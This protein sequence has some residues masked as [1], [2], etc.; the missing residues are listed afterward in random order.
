MHPIKR[1]LYVILSV[2]VLTAGIW[3][4][5]ANNEEKPGRETIRVGF[6]AT[7][8]LHMID[9]GGEKTGYG[10][11]LLRYMSRYLDVS[12][13]YVGYDKSWAEMLR[14]LDDG[15]IDMVAFA[16][17]TEERKEKYDFSRPIGVFGSALFVRED[18]RAVI[19]RDYST[20]EGLRI[21]LVEGNAQNKDIAALAEAMHFTYQP[22]ICKSI[23]DVG[24]ALQKGEVDA[25]V[26]SSLR[27]GIHEKQ[28]ELFAENPHYIIVKKGN[29]R[30]LSEINYAL[31]QLTQV[32]GDWKARLY[33]RYYGSKASSLLQFSDKEKMLLQSYAANGV[34]LQVL[35]DPARYPYSYVENGEMKGIVPDYF[36]RVAA[37][38]GLPFQFVICRSREEWIAYRNRGDC[39]II[40]DGR[41]DAENVLE[42]KDWVSTKPYMTLRVAQV[43]RRDFDGDIQTVATVNQG[44][45]DPIEDYYSQNVR[46]VSYPTRESAMQA[47]ADGKA[48]AAYVFYYMAQEYVNRDQSGLLS[49]TLM[50]EPS[51]PCRMIVTQHANHA[52]AGILTK[53]IYDMPANLLEQIASKYTSYKMK[54]MTFLMMARLHPTIAILLV[55]LMLLLIALLAMA[56]IRLRRM[57][58]VEE[59]KA[60]EMASL[61]EQAEAANRAKSA[62]LSSISHDI[63]TPMNAIIGFTNIALQKEPELSIRKDL[64]KIDISSQHLLTLLNDVLDISRIESGKVKFQP[65]AVDLT[66]LMEGVLEITRG[67]ITDRVLTLSENVPSLPHPFVMADEVRLREVLVNLFSNA[68]KYTKDGGKIS[69]MCDMKELDETHVEVTYEISD[70]G[71]GM[72]EDFV[73][74]I[75]ERFTQEDAG[76]A[77]T[78]YKGAGLGM[79]IT[80]NYVELMGGTI[81]VRSQK[82]VGSTFTVTL[83]MEI[84]DAPL[85]RPDHDASAPADLT[86][87]HV[88]LAEDN[89]LN[90]EIATVQLESLGVD[91]T[92]AV[93]GKEALQLFETRPKGTFDLI[94][95]DIMMPEMDGYEATR[96]IR[97]LAR[98]D[99]RT[100]PILAMTANAF[101]EDVEKSKAAGMNGHLSKPIEIHVVAAMIAKNLQGNE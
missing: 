27:R 89:D 93:N 48:D 12:Y 28:V 64:E 30:L 20:Y 68:I 2:L 101:D 11:D 63:R 35:C 60:K 22:V 56:V 91:A 52:L 57:K 96:A 31:D 81:K 43:V 33:R 98:E 84:A 76:A 73:Q 82:G 15:E 18:N 7:D 9:E 17:K 67:L 74:H 66:F 62:F 10:Y 94:L 61:A 24:I 79:A 88:L 77:R 41:L 3:T 90:A 45:S 83:P 70:T 97:A 23:K 99:A 100:I 44:V 36:R 13:E 37:S 53:A 5:Y 55:L 85:L 51:F 16:N 21:G 95:M 25:I 92:R 4:A 87:I 42:K 72:S 40:L 59:E 8:G 58:R 32:E 50:E 19:P 49:Y 34:F 26:K 69:L 78:E 14:M 38:I 47:V 54:D 65:K 6:F 75:F 80:K 71:I 46:K 39:D 1:L 86:G 29:T